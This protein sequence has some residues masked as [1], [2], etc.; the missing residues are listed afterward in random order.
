MEERR[1]LALKKSQ[2]RWHF[3]KSFGQPGGVPAWS[4]ESHPR[5]HICTEIRKRGQS[6]EQSMIF[7]GSLRE[8]L[9]IIALSGDEG[10]KE[11]P[12]LKAIRSA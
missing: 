6:I 7:I 2:E 3:G 10:H 1:G 11:S 8:R 4:D 12:S 9:A 5:T